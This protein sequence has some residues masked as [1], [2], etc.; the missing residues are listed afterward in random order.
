MEHA[1]NWA[2]VIVAACALAISIWQGVVARTHARRSVR[3]HLVWCENKVATDRG[4]GFT[5]SISNYGIG[6]AVIQ[7][8][9]FVV[10]GTRFSPS[11]AD[12]DTVEELVR[13]VLQDKLPFR[14]L[15]HVLPGMKSAIPQ[16]GKQVIAKLFFPEGHDGTIKTV[17]YYLQEVEFVV[18]YSSIYGEK[19]T[20]R[21]D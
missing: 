3:P 8:R 2:A 12:A 11:A 10:S 19:F 17:R 6:P 21:T 9:Y 15:V 16:G 7:D 18:E 4:V 20:F 13:H 1:S 14:L 5:V